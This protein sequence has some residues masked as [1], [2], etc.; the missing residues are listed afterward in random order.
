MTVS[1]GDRDTAVELLKIHEVDVARF[2]Q[3]VFCTCGVDISALPSWRTHELDV[4]IAHGWGPRPRLDVHVLNNWI[5]AVTVDP[6]DMGSLVT[7]LEGQGI[8]VRE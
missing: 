1:N 8:E 3:G 4:L 5:T 6:T 2:S 7:Y